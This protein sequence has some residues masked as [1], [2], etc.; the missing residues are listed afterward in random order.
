MSQNI[1]NE[2]VVFDCTQALRERDIRALKEFLFDSEAISETELH[3]FLERHP[4]I[5]QGLGFIAIASEFPIFKRDGA[6]DVLF[7]DKRRRDRVDLM[8]ASES[9]ILKPS[10]EIA[11]FA[12][13]IEL[14]GPRD[15][16]SNKSGT[17]LSDQA[18]R[19]IEQLRSYENSLREVQQNRD[20]LAKLGWSISAPR[21]LLV[22]GSRHEFEGQPAALA[23]LQGRARNQ[24][25]E[26]LLIEDL[27]DNLRHV[28]RIPVL[29]TEALLQREQPLAVSNRILA[30]DTGWM[31]SFD[32]ELAKLWN[33]EDRTPEEEQRL[34]EM[35]H[36]QQ[37]ILGIGE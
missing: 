21:K 34:S 1:D 5:F 4:A 14:K 10:G 30:A 8:A 29:H 22:M 12:H 26:H 23:S 19:G 33:Q 15:R 16:F 25:I 11:R 20:L 36:E 35:Y 28:A 6:G 17:R 9:P 24:G 18:S 7:D 31:T 32:R 27:L 2:P 3:R 13:L 37:R